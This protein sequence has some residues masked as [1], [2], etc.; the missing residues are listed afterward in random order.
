MVQVFL[1]NSNIQR[2]QCG[3]CQSHPATWTISGQLL[4][5]GQVKTGLCGKCLKVFDIPAWA[6]TAQKTILGKTEKIVRE[7]IE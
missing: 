5:L 1:H 6:E 4:L 2:G 3:A 7:A